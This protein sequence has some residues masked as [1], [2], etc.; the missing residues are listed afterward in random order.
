MQT[1][2]G[3]VIRIDL[4]TEQKQQLKAAIGKDAQAIELTLRE[5]E[6]RIVPGMALNH[7][8]TLLDEVF[9]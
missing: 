7:N 1:G 4:T 3:Q 5:L 9:D 6:Q 8:E 2:D